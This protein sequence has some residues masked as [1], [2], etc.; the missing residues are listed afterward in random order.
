M[1]S[2]IIL[3]TRRRT[4]WTG[5]VLSYFS[6]I[7]THFRLLIWFYF[8]TLGLSYVF[9]LW[10]FANLYL[11]CIELREF[12][13]SILELA[14][15]FLSSRPVMPQS[16]G[17]CGHLRSSQ[18]NHPT[19]LNCSNCFRGKTCGFCESWT[20]RNVAH[21]IQR[22]R[23]RRNLQLGSKPLSRRDPWRRQNLWRAT[24]ANR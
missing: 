2:E 18:D 13:R 1:T 5:E 6:L 4:H 10:I 11:Y 19:C 22:W 12:G 23:R 3:C 20:S 16:R 7:C 9:Y 21:T 17:L 15:S 24:L 8:I 14:L